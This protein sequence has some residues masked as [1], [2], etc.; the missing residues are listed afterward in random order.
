MD[1]MLDVWCS[2]VYS[3]KM[4]K[5]I[6]EVRLM[7]AVVAVDCYAKNKRLLTDTREHNVLR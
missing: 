3:Q 5:S 2:Y 1:S 6:P 4:R 7:I